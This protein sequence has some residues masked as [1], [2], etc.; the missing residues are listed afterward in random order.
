MDL[1]TPEV[2]A[3]SDHFVACYKEQIQPTVS[4]KVEQGARR[5]GVS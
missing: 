5:S 4:L 2:S 1:V 3:Q